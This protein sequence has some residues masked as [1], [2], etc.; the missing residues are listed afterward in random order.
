MRPQRLT[1]VGIFCLVIGAL[2]FVPVAATPASEDPALWYN[3]STAAAYMFL[4]V[5]VGL[6]I[7]GMAF[8]GVDPAPPTPARVPAPPGTPPRVRR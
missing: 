2:A 3:L 8:R 7:I 6:V 1:L 5:G 4:M